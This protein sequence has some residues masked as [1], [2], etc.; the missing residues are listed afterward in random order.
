MRAKTKIGIVQ[1]KNLI[2]DS[3]DALVAVVE[4][5]LAAI[6]AR[7]REGEEQVEK[8]LAAITLLNRKAAAARLGIS[9]ATLDRRVATGELEA[10]FIDAYPRFRLTEL[11]RFIEAHRQR[12]G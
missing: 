7:A 8:S 12:R 9:V 4:M 1:K 6:L 11:S 2:R 3:L 5:E 10:I